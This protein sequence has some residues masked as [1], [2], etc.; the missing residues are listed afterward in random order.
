MSRDLMAWRLRRRPGLE[1]H[2]PGSLASAT[3]TKVLGGRAWLTA[4]AGS[5][6]CR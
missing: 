6:S 5:G 2:D 1:A 4:D 3:N